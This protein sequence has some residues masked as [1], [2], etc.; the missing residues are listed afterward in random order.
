MSSKA[1]VSVGR[2]GR[3]QGDEGPE[4]GPP[5]VPG[6]WASW[7]GPLSRQVVSTCRL[8]RPLPR[9]SQRCCE[10]WARETGEQ[11][12]RTGCGEGVSRPAPFSLGER[13][14]LGQLI[15]EYWGLSQHISPSG[16]P[17]SDLSRA[18]GLGGRGLHQS[19][20]AGFQPTG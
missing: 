17:R 15:C 13:G 9:R 8:Q 19:C 7:N 12:C 3:E 10:E 14:L 4:S 5:E 16:R 1:V 18:C 2:P 20:R 6:G 11:R